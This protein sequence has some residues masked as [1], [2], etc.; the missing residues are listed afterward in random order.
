MKIRHRDQIAC[1]L[2]LS[3]TV[4]TAWGG[5]KDPEI[6]PQ[7][8]PDW[9][10]RFTPYLWAPGL[11]GSVGV[12]PLTT[13][14]DS[15]SI[16]V[17]EKLKMAA[18]LQFE[19]RYHRWGFMMDGFYADLGADGATPGPIYDSMDV[20]LKQFIG[21]L[22]VAYRVYE[23]PKGFVDAYAGFRYNNLS[24][25]LDAT[26]DVPGIQMVSESASERIISA[27]TE[28]AEAV[29]QPKIEEFKNASAARRD[30][31]AD[32]IR[33]TIRQEAAEQAQETLVRRLKRIRS[34]GD[35]N[36]RDVAISRI[37]R[38]VKAQRLEI[39]RSN[40][41]L[42]I[43]RIR[44]AADQA[45]LA[46]K[47]KI[48]QAESRVNQAE[49]G[50]AKAI[51][52]QLQNRLPTS[53]SADKEWLDPIIGLRAQWNFDERWFLAGKT[54]IGGFGVGSDLAWTMQGTVGYNFT[55]NVSA[56]LGYRYLNTDYSDGDFSYDV[57]EHGMFIGLNMTF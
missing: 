33:S 15:S 32:E 38:A 17:L 6:A 3:A 49:Q 18:A 10:F 28:S 9:E 23:S 57:A 4:G 43:A 56:E 50:L 16:D 26:L 25:D 2:L 40:A 22:S 51:S 35:F 45:N 42:A 1:M 12:G 27:V 36:L 48:A 24:L 20:N 29:I 30:E 53:S 13:D 41:E 44:S 47:E 37:A 14:I 55:E 7:P 5:Q 8:D 34:D 11:T 19:A 54:D 21:E 46:L 31:I 52:T 39:A